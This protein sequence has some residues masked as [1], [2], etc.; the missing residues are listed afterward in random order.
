MTHETAS[1]QGHSI[2]HHPARIHQHKAKAPDNGVAW[3]KPG[4][5]RHKGFCKE[6]IIHQGQLSTWVEGRKT[7][8]NI[9]LS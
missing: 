1:N 5:E 3:S 2:A 8:G 7:E 6:E 4:A 9:C